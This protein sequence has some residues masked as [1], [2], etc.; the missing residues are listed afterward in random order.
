MLGDLGMQC[1]RVG[2]ATCMS[3]CSLASGCAVLQCI[4]SVEAVR[5]MKLGTLINLIRDDD[6]DFLPSSLPLTQLGLIIQKRIPLVARFLTQFGLIVLIAR[7]I[8]IVPKNPTQLTLAL[9]PS[10]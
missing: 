4:T 3:T 9:R 6:D 8:T 10:V 1:M 2:S 7:T 5:T